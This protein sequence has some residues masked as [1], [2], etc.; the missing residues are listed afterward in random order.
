MADVARAAGVSRQTLYNTYAN[1]EEIIRVA[2]RHVTNVQ[3]DT[4]NQ[5]WASAENLGV[6]MDQFFETATLFWY[7]TIATSP[8]SAELIEGIHAA[9]GEE[10]E[11]AHRRM[12]TA[13]EVCISRLVG[14]TV[15]GFSAADLADY[16]YSA[17]S[18]AKYNAENRDQL[19]RRLEV[20][21]ASVL[22]LIGDT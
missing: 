22:A 6:V 3:L 14:E 2:S 16:I 13:L 21:R 10:M 20:L 5:H 19:I 8:E 9:A 4:L 18:S 15:T 11:E 12:T 1:K 7:D 17:A